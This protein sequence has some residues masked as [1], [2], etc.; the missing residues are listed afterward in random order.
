MFRKIDLVITLFNKEKYISR[1]IDS[2]LLQYKK[3]FNKIIIVNDGSIDQS[4]K[5]IEDKYKN[6]SKIKLVNIKNSGVSVARNIGTKYSE[7]KYIVFLDADD[8]LNEHYLFEINKLIDFYPDC[9]IYSTIHKNIYDNKNKD[10]TIISYHKNNLNISSNPIKEFVFNFNIICSSGICVLKKEIEKFQFPENILIGED[11]Y[12]WLKLFS[13]NKIAWSSRELINIYKDSSDRTQNTRFNQL[14]Y[15]LIKKKEII[16]LYKNKFWINIYFIS[17]FFINYFKLN[18]NKK[19]FQDLQILRREYKFNDLAI[20]VIP[21]FIFFFIYYLLSS[22]RHDLK[23][24]FFLIGALFG[25]NVPLI[26]IT[27]YIFDEKVLATE[28]LI[29][30]FYLIFLISLFSFFAKNVLFRRFSNIF[31]FKNISL[32]IITIPLIFICAFIFN[33]FFKLNISNLFFCFFYIIL[34]WLA[35]IQIIFFISRKLYLKYSLLILYIILSNT[36]LVYS[37]IKQIDYYY[38]FSLLILIVYIL[39]NKKLFYFSFAKYKIISSIFYKNFSYRNIFISNLFNNINIFF[40]RYLFSISF[41]AGL[42]SDFF[43]FL[44]LITLPISFLNNAYSE[45]IANIYN[46]EKLYN[47]IS[48]LFIVLI[49]LFFLLN[50]NENQLDKNI[51]FFNS[52]AAIIFVI[53]NIARSRMLGSE[54]MF[55]KLSILDKRSSILFAF[56]LLSVF[57]KKDTLLYIYFINSIIQIFVFQK[58]LINKS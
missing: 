18:N 22:I 55:I 31:F 42:V 7:A 56:L 34:L 26:F 37:L 40:F 11:I 43:F 33:I 17:S 30:Q 24:L 28:F 35:E 9:K 10:N 46:N 32:R 3:E 4:K 2:A 19:I 15:Y 53:V 8:E 21:N 44:F 6:N 50:Y 38:I 25:P 13:V 54:T 52:L 41:A 39:I 23:K 12:V 58:Y 45:Y 16:D 14:P 27:N 51:I 5:V 57:F 49:S 48:I 29:I 20:K 47:V 1:A 36:F